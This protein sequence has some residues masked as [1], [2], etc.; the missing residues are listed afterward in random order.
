[1]KWGLFETQNRCA[2]RNRRTAEGASGV[3][4]ASFLRLFCGFCAVILLLAGQCKDKTMPYVKVVA[5]KTHDTLPQ[6]HYLVKSIATDASGIARVEFIIDDSLTGADSSAPADTYTYDWNDSSYA[7]GSFHSIRAKAWDSVGNSNTS[8]VDVTIAGVDTGGS[9]HFGDI[10][11]A[12]VWHAALNPHYVDADVYVDHNATLTIEPGCVIRFAPGTRLYCGFLSAG[13]IIARGNSDSVITFTSAAATPIPG[14]W[15]GITFYSLAAAGCA[16]DHCTVEYADS[17]AITVDAAV[18]AITNCLVQQGAGYGVDCTPNG[19]FADF[20]NNVITTC[21]RPLHIF[22]QNVTSIGTGNNFL[23][24]GQNQDVVEVNGGSL[25]A[26]ADWPNPGVPYLLNSELAVS[27]ANSPVLTLAPGTTIKCLPGVDIRVGYPS[28][29]GLIADG[30]A[31]RITFTSAVVPPAPGDWRGIEFYPSALNSACRLTNCKI[32]YGGAADSG[33]VVIND[34][35][36]D[37]EQD[38]IG[39]SSTYG[40]Y[41]GA[42]AGPFRD[43]LLAHNSFY[44]DALGPIG[45]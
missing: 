11:S 23:G 9:H 1:M 30:T 43:T 27:G 25:S 10:D 3:F 20:S 19:A 34:V 38:S 29:G 31:G 45:P 4:P 15:R 22:C 32:E 18:V 41:L 33:N 44:F 2:R 14:D 37:I 40:I 7:I 13:R 42:I 6:G 28:P 16:L 8:T 17:A 35:T 5:P 26:S 21:H 12:A 39:Y 36:P 24:N